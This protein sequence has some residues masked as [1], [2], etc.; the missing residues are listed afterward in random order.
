MFQPIAVM[1]GGHLGKVEL[2]AIGL[3]NMVSLNCLT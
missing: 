3:S 1:F 2:D